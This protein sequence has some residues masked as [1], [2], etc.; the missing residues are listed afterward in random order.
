MLKKIKEI[1]QKFI[2]NHIVDDDPCCD[3]DCN[4]GECGGQNCKCRKS[5]EDIKSPFEPKIKKRG[6]PK[7]K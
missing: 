2:K 4:C 5:L 7:K 3:C 6:R 1:I